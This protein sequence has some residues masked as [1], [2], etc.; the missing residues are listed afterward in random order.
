M[1]HTLNEN[2][3]GLYI[4]DNNNGSIHLFKFKNNDISSVEKDVINS[5]YNNILHLNT[6][7]RKYGFLKDEN[8]NNIC[9]R[10]DENSNILLSY[11]PKALDSYEVAGVFNPFEDANECVFIL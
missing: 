4:G 7:L 5:A 11:L 10:I 3:I 1:L 2:E 9:N 8:R 6:V